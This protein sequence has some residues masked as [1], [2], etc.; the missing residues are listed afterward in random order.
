MAAAPGRT[1]LPEVDEVHQRL[2]ALGAHEA[3]G[4]PLLAVAGPVRVDHGAVSGCHSLAELTDLEGWGG[5]PEDTRQSGEQRDTG[6][7]FNSSLFPSWV[8]SGKLLS[9]LRFLICKVG[10]YCPLR[11]LA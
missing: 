5:D 8:T 3:G 7:S 11:R 9:F 6:S 1:V 10:S 4:M 2:G